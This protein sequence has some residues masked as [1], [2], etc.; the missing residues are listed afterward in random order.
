[1]GH[2]Y[3][4]GLY[5][6][7]FPPASKFNPGRDIPDL[8]GRIMIV[9]GGNTGI[10]KET[11]KALL[12]K[13]AK[14]YMASRSKSK[15]EEAIKELKSLTGKEAHF[16]ELDLASLD[17][18][19]KAANEF[20]RRESQLHVLFNSGGV[21]VP[22]IEQLTADGYDLQFGTNVLGHAHFTLLLLP[23]LIEGAK[24]SPDG[25]ARVINTSSSAAYFVGGEGVRYE[26]LKDGP[27]RRN[28]GPNGL[29]SQSKFANALF[30]NELAKRYADQGIVSNAVN[31]GDI[32]SDLQR[33]LSSITRRILDYTFLYPTP[34]GALT[35]LWA[36]VS[37]ETKDLNGQFMIPWARLGTAGKYV[38]KLGEA[39]KLWDWVEE[40][41]KGRK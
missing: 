27:E 40:Q 17:A 15:A 9:T 19:T 7:V 34:M 20:K 37:P 36:G 12:G 18:V 29:Y 16:L 25:K 10:G 6:Q 3:S 22:P 24:T 21:M 39:E 28:M 26:T 35:Q 8:T 31:P 23:E 11:V 5:G 1:M 32:K 30:S 38:K 13:N 2:Y 41:R 33:N 14:V 4:T